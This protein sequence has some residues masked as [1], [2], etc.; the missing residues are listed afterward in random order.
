MYFYEPFITLTIDLKALH[1]HRKLF[2]PINTLNP[3]LQNVSHNI[4]LKFPL[5]TKNKHSKKKN[6]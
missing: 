5:Q 3:G 2:T 4:I 6:H 1:L